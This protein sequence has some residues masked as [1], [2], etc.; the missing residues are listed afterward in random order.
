MYKINQ[1]KLIQAKTK[2]I[3]FK[4]LFE[5]EGFTFVVKFILCINVSNKLISS[6]LAQS[7]NFK[8]TFNKAGS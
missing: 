8:N 5:N 3:F 6:I 4:K 2:L 1:V 7:I